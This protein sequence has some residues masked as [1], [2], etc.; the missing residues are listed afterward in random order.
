MD[1]S[2][3][4]GRDGTSGLQSPRPAALE[5]LERRVLELA[6]SG[7]STAE[8]AGRLGVP[9]DTARSTLRGILARL[10]ARSKLEALIIAIRHRL[11]DLPPS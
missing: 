11:I 2:E 8:V 9:V 6:A 10:G 3:P 5:P 7:L 4:D 1:A